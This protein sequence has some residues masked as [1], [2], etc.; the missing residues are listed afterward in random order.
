MENSKYVELEDYIVWLE[1]FLKNKKSAF[2]DD[3]DYWYSSS[4]NISHDDLKKTRALDKLYDLISEY[5][6]NRGINPIENKHWLDE[7]FFEYYTDDYVL[8][9]NDIIIRIT[10]VFQK[11]TRDN[12][13]YEPT[14]NHCCQKISDNAEYM[15]D[16]DEILNLEK[17]QK[18]KKLILL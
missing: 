1:N 6:H 11:K 8:K 7:I 16:I 4:D 2:R 18:Q 13:P 9:C 17:E 5:M 12:K 3:D 14:L 15:I 10:K